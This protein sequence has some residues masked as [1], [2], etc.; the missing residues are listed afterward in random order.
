M[1]PLEL[2]RYIVNILAGH[3]EAERLAWLCGAYLIA[4]LGISGLKYIVNIK[5][6]GLGESMIRSLAR[7]NLPQWPAS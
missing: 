4:V 6:A 7:G 2:H 1:A 5:S 3:E